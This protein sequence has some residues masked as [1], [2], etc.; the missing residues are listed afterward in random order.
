MTS[1]LFSVGYR[2][3][4]GHTRRTIL[5]PIAQ[6]FRASLLGSSGINFG[7]Y[8]GTKLATSGMRFKI[9]RVRF[10]RHAEPDSGGVRQ[11]EG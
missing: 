11:E 7:K 1:I 9:I 10:G 8:I 2:R 3:P 4:L 6:A 5:S